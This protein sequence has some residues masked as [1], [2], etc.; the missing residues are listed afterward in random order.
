VLL[1]I[2]LVTIFLGLRRL[3]NRVLL[4]RRFA[5]GIGTRKVLI[6]GTGPQADALRHYLE[7]TPHLGYTVK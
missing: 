6:V 3:V 5:R 1:T 2:G 7:S 4:N